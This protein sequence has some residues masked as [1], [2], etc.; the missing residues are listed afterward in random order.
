MNRWKFLWELIIIIMEEICN[1]QWCPILGNFLAVG[2]KDFTRHNSTAINQDQLPTRSSLKN[3]FPW[4]QLIIKG[5]PLKKTGR[6]TST[7]L[8]IIPYT[9]RKKL[10]T[11][12]TVFPLIIKGSKGKTVGGNCDDLVQNLATEHALERWNGTCLGL[13]NAS[14]TKGCP[15]F[16]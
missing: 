6:N 4:K 3:N 12:H 7:V 10:Y 16:S 2:N 14:V 1:L 5:S 15:L 8:K 9:K 13:G 11:P